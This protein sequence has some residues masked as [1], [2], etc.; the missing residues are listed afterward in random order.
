[1]ME[2]QNN[3]LKFTQESVA[4]AWGPEVQSLNPVLSSYTTLLLQTVM[5]PYRCP[6]LQGLHSTVAPITHLS[7]IPPAA[8]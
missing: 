6:A 4:K 2:I 7:A 1:M 3:L 8:L 5:P